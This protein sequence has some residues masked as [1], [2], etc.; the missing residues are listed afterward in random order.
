MIG[1][2]IGGIL[3]LI[4]ICAAMAARADEYPTR[5]IKIIVP[6]GAGG[7]TDLYAR[8][9]AS[10]L[11]PRLGQPVV[12][13]D[14]PGEGGN[15]GAAFVAR[16]APD[17]YTLLI[18]SNANTFGQSLYHDLSF[19]ILTDFAPITR[20]GTIVNVFV[21]NRPSKRNPFKM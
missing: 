15:F 4:M 11:E 9:I 10:R 3:T 19:N 6:F 5:P 8:E 20:G 2:W 12:V 16:A 21:V 17:G 14:R 1:R 13:E 7:I 18:G